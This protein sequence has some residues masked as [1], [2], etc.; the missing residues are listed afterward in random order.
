MESRPQRSAWVLGN[1]LAR[2]VNG[3]WEAAVR[4]GLGRS[5]RVEILYPQGLSELASVARRA[6]SSGGLIVVAGGDGSLN[7]VVNTVAPAASATTLAI[8]PLGTANDLARELGLP[9]A[10]AEAVARIVDGRGRR[11]DLLSVNGR[12]FCTVGGVGVAAES[13]L[14]VQALRDKGGVV[15]DALAGMGLHGY[16]LV[17]GAKVLGTARLSD[18]LHIR[19]QRPGTGPEEELSLDVHALF[20]ANQGTLGGRLRVSPGSRNDDGVF[21]LC[22]LPAASRAALLATLGRLV[23]GAPVPASA[24]RVVPITRASIASDRP[25]VFF[26]DGER[27]CEDRRFEISLH[28][29]ALEVVGA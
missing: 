10:P 12:R 5:F 29:G 18:R 25:M 20:V 13:A 19:L 1:R 6:S 14:A 22:L 7:C 21:E 8:L 11:I 23:G 15:R 28:P 4:E 9:L 3:A 16:W 27:L 26:G 24:L 2:G 17:A